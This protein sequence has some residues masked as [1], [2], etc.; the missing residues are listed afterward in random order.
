[1]I[2]IVKIREIAATLLDNDHELDATSELE[3]QSREY[4]VRFAD[5]LADLDHMGYSTIIPP[6][7]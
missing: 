5:I 7:F 3:E 6:L 2:Q 1:M 4:V